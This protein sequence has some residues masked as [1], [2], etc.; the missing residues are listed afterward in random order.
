VV[1]VPN[2][3]VPHNVVVVHDE[4]PWMTARVAELSLHFW[5]RSQR[6]LETVATPEPERLTGMVTKPLRRANV[7][8]LF[9][10]LFCKEDSSFRPPLR[11]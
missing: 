8:R 5:D 2:D 11:G 9:K 6:H 10:L 1:E 7:V 3:D 4:H